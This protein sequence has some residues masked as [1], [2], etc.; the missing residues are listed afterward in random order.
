MYG[1]YKNI[2]GVMVVVE[3]E[4]HLL[5]EFSTVSRGHS[6]ERHH[7]LIL[8]RRNGEHIEHIFH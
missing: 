2:I 5:S 3:M 4:D 6:G 7:W 8:S 1:W